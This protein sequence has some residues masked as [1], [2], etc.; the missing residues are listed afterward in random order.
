MKK[1]LIAGLVVA[2]AGSTYLLGGGGLESA[3]A[4]PATTLTAPGYIGATEALAMAAEETRAQDSALVWVDS[5]F[6]TGLS[7]P[8]GITQLEDGRVLVGE[9]GAGKVTAFAAR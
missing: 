1:L 5:V 6:A 7:D 2:L 4:A 8:A 3:I 9:F